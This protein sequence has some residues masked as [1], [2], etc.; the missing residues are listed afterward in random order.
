MGREKVVSDKWASRK[1]S[2]GRDLQMAGNYMLILLFNVRIRMDLA[3]K[4]FL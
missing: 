2:E 1:E 4:F 3:A